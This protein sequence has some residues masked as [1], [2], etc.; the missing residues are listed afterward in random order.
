MVGRIEDH[1]RKCLDKSGQLIDPTS[2]PWSGPAV[3]KSAHR[4]FDARKFRGKLL[5]AAYRHQ[6]HWTE[7]IGPGIVQSIPYAWWKKFNVSSVLVAPTLEKPV[8]ED[9][10]S[11]LRKIPDF[12]RMVGDEE[13]ASTDFV[14]LG[15]SLDTITQFLAGYDDLRRWVRQE[16]LL[17]R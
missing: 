2:L 17:M 15:A 5:A 6:L 10:L 1:L 8:A 12:R 3:F 9:V 11:E 14:R 7:L 16:M 4:I 13:I